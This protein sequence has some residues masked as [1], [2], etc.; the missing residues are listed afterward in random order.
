MTDNP[1]SISVYILVIKGNGADIQDT[2][3][4]YF[5][6]FTWARP[7]V[8]G[9]IS[10]KGK[11][12]SVLSCTPPNNPGDGTLVTYYVERFNPNW[13][14]KHGAQK[15]KLKYRSSSETDNLINYGA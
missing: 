15:M 9:Q 12:Y 10:H 5:R 13:P 3:V 14:Y 2:I 1:S 11:K 8:G 6:S 4:G 7:F